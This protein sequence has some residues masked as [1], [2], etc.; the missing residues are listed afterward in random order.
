[1]Y[2]KNFFFLISACALKSSEKYNF[3]DLKSIFT[4]ESY[5]ELKEKEEKLEKKMKRTEKNNVLTNKNEIDSLENKNNIKNK[6]P[7][8]QNSLLKKADGNMKIDSMFQ[9]SNN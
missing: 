3:I 1:V 9:F 6:L 4:F 5:E 8:N 2:L 7:L